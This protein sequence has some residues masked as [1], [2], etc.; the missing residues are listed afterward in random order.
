[1][2]T[3]ST[4]SDFH[5]TTMLAHSLDAKSTEPHDLTS[6]ST[7][8]VHKSTN[9]N[10]HLSNIQTNFLHNTPRQQ[11][12]KSFP[13]TTRGKAQN[14]NNTDYLELNPPANKYRHKDSP[15][16]DLENSPATVP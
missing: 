16:T 11:N 2:I 3:I 5:E 7:P 4:T 1:M 9:H 10:N 6:F 15:Q 13:F 14:L 8:T 12:R